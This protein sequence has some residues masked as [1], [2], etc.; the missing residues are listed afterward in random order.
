MAFRAST[1]AVAPLRATQLNKTILSKSVKPPTLR[2]SS[3]HTSRASFLVVGQKFH[4]QLKPTLIIIDFLNT[5]SWKRVP[6]IELT[7]KKKLARK[8]VSSCEPLRFVF[9]GSGIPAAFSGTCSKQ[10]LPGF[11]SHL[12]GLRQR[13]VQDIYVISVNDPFVM[14][15][16]KNSFGTDSS[17]IV[18]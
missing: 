4:P 11:F 18:R 13:G 9:N 12:V 5:P 7:S 8:R 10:H 17:V 6:P 1:R 14:N 2:T 15:A 3:F 16:W